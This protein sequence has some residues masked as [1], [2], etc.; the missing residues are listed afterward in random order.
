M[1]INET[2][3]FKKIKGM[4]V[5][6]YSYYIY[7][8]REREDFRTSDYLHGSMYKFM[9]FKSWTI[10]NFNNIRRQLI[11]GCKIVNGT[12]RTT[13]T[14]ITGLNLLPR[15]QMVYRVCVTLSQIKKS[16]SN[17]RQYFHISSLKKTT[18]CQQNKI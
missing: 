3:K 2:L 5:I 10:H 15:R 18:M 11:T 16:Q 13:N 14:S 8:Q 9:C 7:T 12:R 4:M 6:K 17:L 1:D